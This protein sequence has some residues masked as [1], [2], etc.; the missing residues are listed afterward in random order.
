M[1]LNKELSLKISIS[2]IVL[3]GVFILGI[4]IGFSQVPSVNKVINISNTASAETT[5]TDFDPFWKAWNIL[6]DKSINNESISD[7]DK[8]WGAIEGLASSY[9]DPYTVFFPP[10]EN[11]LFN[12]TIRGSFGGIGAEI[13]IKNKALTVVSPLKDSPAQKAGIKSGDVI[14]KIGTVDT[15][16]MS[17]DTAISLIRGEKGTKITLTV[18][19][20]GE[21]KTREFNITRD[22]VEI[23]TIETEKRITDETFIIKFYSFSENSNKLFDVALQEFKNTNY[24]RLILDLRGNPGGYLDVAI[25]IASN[26]LDEGKIIAIEDFGDSQKK[27]S[28][29]SYGPRLFTDKLKFVVLVD[30]GSASASEILAGALKEH[31]IATIVGEKTFGKGSVQELVKVTDTTSLKITIAKWLTPNG[32]SISDHG[33]DPDIKVEYTEKDFENKIDPQLNK[34]VEI[35]KGK[36]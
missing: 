1:K 21:K 19:R 3:A 36:N 28:H 27:V 33:L 20:Q 35:L 18:F 12:D 17:I 32:T 29:R 34:A 4:Y 2:T 8:V 15:K 11:K 31:K 22:I 23:P 7:Q 26:F 9:N 16:D 5:T 6:K 10:D 13:G 24:N 30:G 25:D 14:L